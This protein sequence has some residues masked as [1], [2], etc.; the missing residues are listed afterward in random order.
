MINNQNSDSIKTRLGKSG[1]NYIYDDFPLSARIA[2]F[3]L[4][5]DLINRGFLINKDFILL[6]LK[7]IG[8]ITKNDSDGY[9]FDGFFD[10]FQFYINKLDWIS[11][12]S[13]IERTYEKLLSETGHPFDNNYISLEE[14]QDYFGGLNDLVQRMR[15]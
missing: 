10:Y 9:D 3:Y 11:V 14:V 2:L 7:R 5:K 6:E 15:S 13:F 12:L 1:K 4:Y 8:R